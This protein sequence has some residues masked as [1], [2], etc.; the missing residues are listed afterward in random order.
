MLLG[1]AVP[2]TCGPRSTEGLD[3]GFDQST[4]VTSETA[5]DAWQAEIE[6]AWADCVAP[7]AGGH[8]A[9]QVS[10]AGGMSSSRD[11]SFTR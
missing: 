3:G 2:P 6:P 4:A 11:S 1:A 9:V 7:S 8:T 10:G 5:Y